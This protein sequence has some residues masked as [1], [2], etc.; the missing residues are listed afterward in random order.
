MVPDIPTVRQL[1][2]HLSKN[3]INKRDLVISPLSPKT[4]Y[5]TQRRL[6]APSFSSLAI[7]IYER[8]HPHI[9]P[10]LAM[11]SVNHHSHPCHHRIARLPAGQA[12]LEEAR[13]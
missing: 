13:L 4:I 12:S 5:S 1:L 11:P 3:H 10:A 7:T 8:R 9:L 6:S 2:T